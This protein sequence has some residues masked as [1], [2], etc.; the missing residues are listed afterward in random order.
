MLFTGHKALDICLKLRKWRVERTCYG[1]GE[2]GAELSKTEIYSSPLTE[3]VWLSQQL[4]RGLCCDTEGLS[5]VRRLKLQAPHS[6]TTV[7]L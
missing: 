5:K 6:S 7:P 1:P 3:K 2:R 4:Y